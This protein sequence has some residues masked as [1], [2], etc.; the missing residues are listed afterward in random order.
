MIQASIAGIFHN[1]KGH[2]TDRLQRKREQCDRNAKVGAIKI[3]LSAP[4]T[5]FPQPQ[6]S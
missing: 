4:R 5:F 6:G 1:H 2:D 3:A